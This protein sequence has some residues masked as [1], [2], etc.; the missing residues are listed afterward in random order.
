MR[1]ATQY[2]ETH[3]WIDGQGRQGVTAQ[4]PRF[5]LTMKAVSASTWTSRR[6]AP[7]MN[8]RRDAAVASAI[9]AIRLGRRLSHQSA[10]PAAQKSAA[11]PCNIRL[12]RPATAVKPTMPASTAIVRRTATVNARRAG[13]GVA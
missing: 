12:V 5:G 9:A 2:D 13:T 1:A 11:Q 10:M 4:T 6:I 3:E 8:R 7:A